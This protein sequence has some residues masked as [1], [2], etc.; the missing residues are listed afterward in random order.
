MLVNRNICTFI[1][2]IKKHHYSIKKP[3]IKMHS[4]TNKKDWS[5]HDG[6]RYRQSLCARRRCDRRISAAIFLYGLRKLSRPYPSQLTFF[7]M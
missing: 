1:G 3:I 4:R 6:S 7:Y 2:L 5:Y